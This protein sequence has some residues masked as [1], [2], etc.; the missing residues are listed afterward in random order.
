[1]MATGSDASGS[2]SKNGTDNPMKGYEEMQARTA[3]R[4]KEREK[5]A[6]GSK[7]VKRSKNKRVQKSQEEK[8]TAKEANK[9]RAR[10]LTSL[11]A[12][13]LESIQHHEEGNMPKQSDCTALLPVA[14]K[15]AK[16]HEP[17]SKLIKQT[18]LM[19]G[20][21]DIYSD[22]YDIRPRRREGL[23]DWLTKVL[24]R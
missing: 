23:V 12:R 6:T 22:I 20:L 4:K 7:P 13:A 21:G 11:L 15:M 9:T 10:E 16:V 8:E 24:Y 14:S 19:E 17:C 3:A 18:E 2:R 1:M 5:N